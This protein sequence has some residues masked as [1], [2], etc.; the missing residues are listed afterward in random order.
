M[1]IISKA[2]IIIEIFVF[3]SIVYKTPIDVPK[4]KCE[5][6]SAIKLKQLNSTFFIES[7]GLTINIHIIENII[8]IIP[9]IINTII[10]IVKGI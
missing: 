6:Y 9:I 7:I 10:L 4:R 2:L 3:N 8:A 5:I 1:L